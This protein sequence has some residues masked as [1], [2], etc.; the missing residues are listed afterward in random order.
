MDDHNRQ[1]IDTMSDYWNVAF[2][3]HASV[4]GELRRKEMGR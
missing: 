1:D 3:G 2:Y 4:C